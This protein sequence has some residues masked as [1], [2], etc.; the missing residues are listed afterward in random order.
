MAGSNHDAPFV[1]HALALGMTVEGTRTSVHGR[2]QHVTLQAENQFTDAVVG[3]GTY[4]AQL[5]LIIL[6]RPCLHAPVFV[7]NEY[8][9]VF[10][11]G[12]RTY[13][14][15][16]IAIDS[17]VCPVD[18]DI[19][20]P[21]PRTDTDGLAD[22][23]DSVGQASGIRTRNAELA[24]LGVYREPFP[25]A[26]QFAV[27]MRLLGRTDADARTTDRVRGNLRSFARNTFYIVG[28]HLSHVPHQRCIALV[29]HNGCPGQVHGLSRG[30]DT[31]DEQQT[32]YI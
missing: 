31:H 6:C 11:T 8:A 29:V 4:I 2:C 13:K 21:I 16:G 5:A 12:R 20:K 24:L 19:G 32:A 17:P 30:P 26:L 28:Q 1:G 27:P 23:E 14:G 18:G 7:V 22:A 15:L 3:F 25:S 9:T 10:Y